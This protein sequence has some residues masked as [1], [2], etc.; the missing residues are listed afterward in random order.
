MD[1]SWPDRFSFADKAETEILETI[2]R[3]S[4]NSIAA[5]KN[6]IK[7]PVLQSAVELLDRADSICAI[8]STGAFPVAA[9]LAQGLTERG[10]GCVIYSRSGDLAKPDIR[11]FGKQDL[12]ILVQMPGSELPEGALLDA[13]GRKTPVLAIAENP[14]L[15][16]AGQV[17]VRLPVPR[18]GRHEL[19]NLPGFMAVAEL[20]LLAFDRH[21]RTGPY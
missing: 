14:V 11:S 6:V 5:L 13:G 9:L 12:L 17:S 21:R 8:G 2:S 18:A 16:G 7:A 10:R 3:A 4:A 15:P 20:L 1:H 19:P